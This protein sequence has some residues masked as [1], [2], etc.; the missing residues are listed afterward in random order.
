[1]TEN[2][3]TEMVDLY[4]ADALPDALRA[5]VERHLAAHPDAAR[6]AAT[7]QVAL[8]RLH[9]APFERPD[10]WFVERLLDTLL[11]EHA[12]ETPTPFG[13]HLPTRHASHKE[14][15]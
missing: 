15:T 10:A 14:T 2:E 8:T 11:R 4:V 9:S 3:W 5:S 13:H 6:D 12:A 1:M 7:L